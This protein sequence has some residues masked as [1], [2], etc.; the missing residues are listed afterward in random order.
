L[1]HHVSQRGNRRQEVFFHEAD[2]AAYLALLAARKF[3]K[4][5]LTLVL[6]PMK[7]DSME[8]MA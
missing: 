5:A 6:R 1:P 3:K 7:P 4:K 2:Y 8:S